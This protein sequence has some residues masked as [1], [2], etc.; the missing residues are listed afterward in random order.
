MYLSVVLEMWTP[1]SIYQ[2]SSEIKIPIWSK[3]SINKRDL[4]K[5]EK[6]K[7][8]GAAAQKKRAV[9]EESNEYLVEEVRKRSKSLS[10]EELDE[11]RKIIIE[12]Q[13]N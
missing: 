12:A 4:I 3:A 5:E 7:P 8:K 13:S 11:L 6:R 9:E 1:S 2:L 10:P